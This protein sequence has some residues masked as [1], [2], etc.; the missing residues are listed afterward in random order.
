MDYTIFV[1][2]EVTK[3]VWVMM[4]L[5]TNEEPSINIQGLTQFIVFAIDGE[6]ILRIDADGSVIYRNH[7]C[8][9]EPLLGQYVI[10][11]SKKE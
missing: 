8:G 4:D 2:P 5:R 10:D 3:S 6:E 11:H 9:H 7:V 1:P